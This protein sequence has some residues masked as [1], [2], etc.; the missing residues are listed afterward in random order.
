VID[1]Q[2]TPTDLKAPMAEI[3]GT[4]INLMAPVIEIKR[5]EIDLMGTITEIQGALGGSMAPLIQTWWT[6]LEWN[7]PAVLLHALPVRMTS[8]VA[9]P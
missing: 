4:E 8:D 6:P 7:G 5:T 2:P 3:Q 1:F 9:R